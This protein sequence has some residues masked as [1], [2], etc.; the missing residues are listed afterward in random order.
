M[1]EKGEGVNL[2]VLSYVGLVSLEK[3]GVCDPLFEGFFHFW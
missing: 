3:C 2:M 1:C